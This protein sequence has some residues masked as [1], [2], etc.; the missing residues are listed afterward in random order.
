MPRAYLFTPLI[1]RRML[2]TGCVKVAVG[3]RGQGEKIRPQQKTKYVLHACIHS[4]WA[5]WGSQFGFSW[6]ML[7]DQCLNKPIEQSL[8]IKNEEVYMNDAIHPKFQKEPKYEIP[9][10]VTVMWKL[11][12]FTTSPVE[13]WWVASKVC[14]KRPVEIDILGTAGRKFWCPC[15]AIQDRIYQYNK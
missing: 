5:L 3:C 4:E 7:E 1:R 6:D 2:F 12:P 8:E 14:F 10:S 13:E 11:L 9:T 15:W